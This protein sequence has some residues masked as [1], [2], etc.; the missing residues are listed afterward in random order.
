MIPR[1]LLALLLLLASLAPSAQAATRAQMLTPLNTS[2]RGGEQQVYSV[3]FLDAM[4]H[5]A[6]GETVHFSND[7]CGLFPNGQF[8]YAAMTDGDGIASAA[9]TAFSQGI[10]CTVSAVDGVA[11]RFNVNTYT[12]AQVQIE[13]ELTPS[14]P[15]PG[16]PFTLSAG[17]FQ[18]RFPI[19]EADVTARVIPGTIT[20]TISPGSANVGQS[21]TGVDF[22][23][24]PEDRIGDFAVEVAYR[25]VTRRFAFTAPPSPLQDMWW[26][27]AAENGWGMSVVQHRDLLF[28]VVYAYD[29]A[30]KPIWYVMPGGAWNEAKTAFTG[31]LYVPT[32]TPFASYDASKLAAN[33]PVG[34]A[35]ITFTGASNGTLDF[36]IG[37]VTGRKAITRQLFGPEESGAP[38]TGLGDMWWGGPS[39][40]GWGIAVLQQYKSLF[41]VWFT[42]DANGKATWFVMPAGRWATLD[43][44]EGRI[45]RTAGSPWLG[46]PYDAAKLKATDVGPFRVRFSGGD[47]TFDY[48]VDGASGSNPLTRQPF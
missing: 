37:G 31:P 42:Y 36:I 47:A 45:Y 43:S 27:G 14:E 24:T 20:A 6:A 28:S 2:V 40:N 48:T 30:G 10:T 25:G 8:N 15:R 41:G 35:T 9:F 16:Q 29:A 44:Y 18:G 13:G 39:Q 32:G 4:N 46:Q 7:A 12:L 26:A 17:P 22:S 23:V 3:R 1:P 34:S 21:T 11:V 33:D 5:P 38:M 19:Y